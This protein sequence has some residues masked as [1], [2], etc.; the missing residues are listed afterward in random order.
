MTISKLIA[1]L[2]VSGDIA[3]EKSIQALARLGK[4]AIPELLLAASNE[5]KPRIRKWSLE[6][7]GEIGDR[8]ALPL[9]LQALKDSRMTVRLHALRALARLNEKSASK[10]IAP[11][12][13]DPSGGIRVNAL[14]CLVKLNVKTANPYLIRALADEEWYVQQWACKACGEF[15]VTK[16]KTKLHSLANKHPRNA[17]RE[18]A[19]AALAKIE[20]QK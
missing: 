1:S 12:L 16:A 15:Q 20:G 17:V 11:L 8:R 13:R 14:Q 4:T 3:A 5:K 18:A 6:A 7:L 10:K 2:D 19:K 9:L